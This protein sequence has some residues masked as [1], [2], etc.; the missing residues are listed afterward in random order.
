MEALGVNVDD[1]VIGG[2]RNITA[3]LFLPKLSGVDYSVVETSSHCIEQYFKKPDSLLVD[4]M[5][6]LFVDAG[7]V[8]FMIFI[9]QWKDEPTYQKYHNSFLTI[10]LD[11][12]KARLDPKSA[13]SCF[14]LRWSIAF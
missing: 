1:R 3:A 7:H 9:Y 11:N 6:K 12:L 13:S 10:I 4:L 5:N 14:S 2:E 8:C